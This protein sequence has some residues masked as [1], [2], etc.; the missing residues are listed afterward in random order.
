MV[1]ARNTNNSTKTPTVDLWG[2]DIRYL[3]STVFIRDFKPYCSLPYIVFFIHI[4]R[5]LHSPEAQQIAPQ[6][7]QCTPN[8]D[9][10]T[11]SANTLVLVCLIESSTEKF[12]FRSKAGGQSPYVSCIFT[13]YSQHH[14]VLAVH[15]LF[16]NWELTANKNLNAS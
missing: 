13:V 16:P 12:Y 7:R 14:N 8:V 1:Q 4:P 9:H 15:P 10:N 11:R 6:M 5:P 2:M 3:I